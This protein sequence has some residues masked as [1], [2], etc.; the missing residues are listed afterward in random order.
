M[1]I[2]NSINNSINNFL[3]KVIGIVKQVS[4][5]STSF[6]LF[7][8]YPNPF[9]PLTTINFKI[10]PTHKNPPAHPGGKGVFMKLVK[11]ML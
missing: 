3:T 7:Q 5:F 11:L 2:I 8:N 1:K 9:N 6:M 4:S 10:P